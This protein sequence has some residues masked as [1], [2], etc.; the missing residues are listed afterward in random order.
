MPVDSQFAEC[1]SLQI[2]CLCRLGQVRF[3]FDSAAAHPVPPIG[4]TN[5]YRK[6]AAVT[7]HATI[8]FPIPHADKCV[9]LDPLREKF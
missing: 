8:D 1:M 3:L 4:F 2:P 5:Q 6:A 7:D 9:M